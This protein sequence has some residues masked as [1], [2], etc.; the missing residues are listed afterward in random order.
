M[1]RIRWGEFAFLVVMLAVCGW[2]LFESRSFSTR[3]FLL[4]VI[5]AGVAGGL[6]LLQLGRVLRGKDDVDRSLSSFI[7]SGSQEHDAGAEHDVDSHG[8]EQASAPP[9]VKRW[10]ESGSS[11]SKTPLSPHW[12]SFAWLSAMTAL[13]A[14]LGLAYGGLLFTVLYMRFRAQDSVLRIALVAGVLA[15]LL[16]SMVN[17]LG[18]RIHSGI[19][20]S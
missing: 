3:A 7:A 11:A 4:P 6:G 15:A 5:G 9:A 17:F 18:A 2:I 13:V 14:L 12:L 19:L 10:S 1:R 20:F 16:Y 8:A